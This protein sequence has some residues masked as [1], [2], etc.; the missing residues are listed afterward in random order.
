MTS[1]SSR[2]EPGLHRGW[3]RSDLVAGLTSA[4]VVLPKAMGYATLAGLPVQGG[5]YTAFVPML[6]YALLGTSRVLSVST[7]STLAIVTV[8]ALHN[9]LPNAD[10]AGLLQAAALLT[11]MAGGTLILAAVLRLGF[12]ANFISEPVLVG[13]Q[14]GIGIVIVVDQLPKILGI[15]ISKGSLL[16]NLQAIALGLPHA[17]IPTLLLGAVTL[18]VLGV[19]RRLRPEWPAPLILIAA[20]VAGVAWLGWGEH[21]IEVVGAMPSGLPAMSVPKLALA[22]QLW[23]AALALAFM[24]FTE[25]AAAGRAF[26]RADEPRPRENR[27]LLAIG[28]A[29][30]LGSLFGAMPAGGG[31]S[32]TAVN[33][34]AGARTQVAGLT[35][36]AMALLTMLLLSPLVALMPQAALAAIVIFYSAKLIK[37][38][39]F[40][41]IRQIRHREFRWAVVA[42][43]GVALLGTLKGILIAIIFSLVALAEQTANPPVFVLGRKPGTNVFRPRS[44][45]H[46]EDETLP[47]L[48]L[49]RIEGVVFFLNA[50]RIG[51]KLMPLINAAQPKVVALDLGGVTDLEFSALKMLIEAERRLRDSGIE[52]WL[53][54]LTPGVLSVVQRSSLGAT[55]GRERLLFDLEIAVR[56]F[57]NMPEQR[58]P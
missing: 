14:A 26:A 24:S 29:N 38:G 48:L 47:G 39:D 7:T 36:A 46:P 35:T 9:V 13:F 30:A 3:L 23:P 11:L 41:A 44:P 4:A 56:N 43:L 31:T 20:E 21:G 53:V 19:F 18:A 57:Q 22:D 10:E 50:Q 8:T 12:V 6:V 51:A 25:T 42:L 2:L 27:E 1:P 49:L 55:L 33:R 28:V 45:E 16:H 17:S 32:Q 5:L 15:H 34:M 37:P 58:K 54:R 40:R 52:L